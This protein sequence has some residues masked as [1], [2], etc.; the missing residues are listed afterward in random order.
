M[1]IPDHAKQVFHGV[2]FDVYQWEQEM[3]DGT[4]E[5][6][7]MVQRSTSVEAIAIRD[8]KIVIAHEEQPLK[9]TFYGLFGGKQELSET[10]LEACKRELRE[11]SGFISDDW[12]LLYSYNSLPRT[13][14]VNDMYVARNVVKV[15]S[16]NL[17]SGEKITILEV[18]F[19]EFMELIVKE[20]FRINPYFVINLLRMHYENPKK[21][22]EFKKKLGLT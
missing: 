10:S 9:G 3:F 6:F 14:F 19:D 2:I 17:D 18:N 15:D 12:E 1:K 11:E 16:Q 4:L 21:L 13:D 7:E 5:T 20:N 8:N 22:E